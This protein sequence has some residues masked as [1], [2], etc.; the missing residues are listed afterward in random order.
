LKGG[1]ILEKV[2]NVKIDEDL[3]WK[4]KEILIKEK[5]TM[6]EGVEKAISEYIFKIKTNL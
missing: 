3:Y 5:I 1:F 6:K 4:L 2:I